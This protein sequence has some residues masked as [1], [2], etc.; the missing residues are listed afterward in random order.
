MKRYKQKYFEVGPME[1]HHKGDWVKFED[2]MAL[3]EEYSD[4]VKSEM[5]ILDEAIDELGLN[6][7][8]MIDD[9]NKVAEQIELSSDNLDVIY[10][11]VK[12]WRTRLYIISAIAVVEAL[13]IGMVI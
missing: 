12:V 3:S 9:S 1:E 6:V 13:I 4:Y 10:E 11:K 8:G 7:N 2:A 5:K